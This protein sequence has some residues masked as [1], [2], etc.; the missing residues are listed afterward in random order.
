MSTRRAFSGVGI[1]VYGFG[2][3]ALGLVGLVWR[4]FASVWQPVP[5]TTPHRTALAYIATVLLLAGGA[6]VQ[7]RRIA[8]AGIVV[9]AILYFIFALLWL[10][11]VFGYPQIFATW[12]GFFEQL[13]LVAAGLVAY[14]SLA[15]SHSAWPVITARIGRFFYGICVLS[16]ALN[17]FFAL[18]ETARMVPAWVAPGQQFWAVATGVFHLLAG[19]AILSGVLP[20][21]ASWLLTAMLGTFGAL[22]WAP[23]LFGAPHEHM[24][25]AGNAI[26]LAL[27]GGAWVIADAMV[28]RR[29]QIHGQQDANGSRHTSS[30]GRPRDVTV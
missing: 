6:A 8:Q 12:G 9:L 15:P 16:F 18:K 26:N 30:P 21:L 17:H 13:S 24:V 23:S 5:A 1:H 2:A 19:M 7:W 3:I 25:W 28:S 11:R 29:E 27:T 22:V 20:V 10:P 4:D 14:A